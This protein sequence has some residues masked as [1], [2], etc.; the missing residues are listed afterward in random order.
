M[1]KKTLRVV[2]PQWQGGNNFH[3]YLGAQLLAW[4]APEEGSDTIE[5][6]ISLA[7]TKDQ[8]EEGIVAKQQ[9][10]KQVR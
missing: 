1:S 4:L 8:Q 6:S 9:I 3:Y 2:M 7:P 5:A 10:L